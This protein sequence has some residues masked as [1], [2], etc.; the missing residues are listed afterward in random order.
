M[1]LHFDQ[2][3]SEKLPPYFWVVMLLNL[4]RRIGAIIINPPLRVVQI[5]NYK[6][7]EYYSCYR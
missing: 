7:L 1:P 6:E 2:S 4:I 3:Y 5:D